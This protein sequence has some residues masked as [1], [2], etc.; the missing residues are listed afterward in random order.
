MVLELFGFLVLFVAGVGMTGVLIGAI[1][2]T[3]KDW[4]VVWCVF[5]ALIAFGLFWEV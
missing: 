5:V 1:Y 4:P 3:R 2:A